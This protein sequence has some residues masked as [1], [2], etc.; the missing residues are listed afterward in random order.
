MSHI[1]SSIGVNSGGRTHW[2]LGQGGGSGGRAPSDGAGP[3]QAAAPLSTAHIRPQ[4]AEPT[5]TWWEKSSLLKVSKGGHCEAVGGGQRGRIEG[6]SAQSRKRL[7]RT[8][9]RVRRDADLPLFITLT[10]PDAFPD[11]LG[12]KRHLQSII[13]RV[14]RAHPD[15]GLIWKLEPQQRGAPHYNWLLWGVG[16]DAMQEWMPEAWYEIAGGNDIKHLQ[17]HEGK[18]GNRHCVDAVRDYKGVTAYAAKYLGKTFIIAGWKWVGQ[19]WGVVM[20]ENIPF[21]TERNAPIN[22]AS[23]VNLQR[24]QRRFAHIKSR[25]HQRSLTTFCDAEQWIEKAVSGVVA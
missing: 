17:W 16:L 4:G 13:K 18:L 19:Y 2:R 3:R 15:A 23:A 21:G 12:S 5:V 9:A 6:F 1:D 25:G 22:T 11:G 10:Y 7:L 24:M 14:R 8:V 20:P